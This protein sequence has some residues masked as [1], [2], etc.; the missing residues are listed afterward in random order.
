MKQRYYNKKEDYM[1]R[2][3]MALIIGILALPII[4]IKECSAQKIYVGAGLSNALGYGNKFSDNTGWLISASHEQ[5]CTKWL[6]GKADLYFLNQKSKKEAEEITIHSVNIGFS[7][8]VFIKSFYLNPGASVGFVVNKEIDNNEEDWN[9]PDGRVNASIAA[10]YRIRNF[11]L[12][13]SYQHEL[14]NKYPITGNV[15]LA[16]LYR[17]KS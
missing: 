15:Q 17:I 6:S 3:K 4:L 12:K 8:L 11:D 14:L 1:N 16:L 7:G 10:G 9:F 13:A 5:E 2:L